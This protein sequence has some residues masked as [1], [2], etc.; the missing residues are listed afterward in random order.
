MSTATADPK[1]SAPL[2]G[3]RAVVPQHVEP[4]KIAPVWLLWTTIFWENCVNLW[5]D[6][7]YTVEFLAAP[8]FIAIFKFLVLFFASFVFVPMIYAS[9]EWKR[10]GMTLLRNWLDCWLVSSVVITVLTLL[11]PSGTLIPGEDG[12]SGTRQ[13]PDLFLSFFDDL[14]RNIF[15]ANSSLQHATS[16]ALYTFCSIVLVLWLFLCLRLVAL[17]FR[18]ITPPERNTGSNPASGSTKSIFITVLSF[19]FL[20][21]IIAAIIRLWVR[22]DNLIFRPLDF[23]SVRKGKN[24]VNFFS[25]WSFTINVFS[26]QEWILYLN[27]TK[28]DQSC[29]PHT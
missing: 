18:W 15:T 10:D 7:P 21:G 29:M 14:A 2:S 11:Q 27:A 6:A 24:V 22:R 23:E 3:D 26:T 13:N 4:W 16:F 1:Y 25:C 17:K 12:S 28:N 8:L 9:R 20:S 19:A 5:L